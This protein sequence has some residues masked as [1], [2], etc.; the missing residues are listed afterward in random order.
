RRAPGPPGGGAAG[1]FP[2]APRPRAPAGGNE[3]VAAAGRIVLMGAL[4]ALF[5][6]AL[7]VQPVWA[8]SEPYTDLRYYMGAL[9]LLLAMKGLFVEWAWRRRRIA[10]AAAGAVLL[11]SSAGAWPFNITMLFTGERTLGLH[12]FQFVREIHRP[13]RDSI[14]AVSDHLLQHAEQDDLVYVAGF[15]DRETLMFT[16]GHRVLFCCILDE[17]SPLPR[18]TI[19]ALGPHVPAG[20]ITPDWIILFGKPVRE[21][22]Q[23]VT[24]HYSVAVQ[25]NVYYYPT[26]RPEINLHAFTPLP[27][28][29]YGVHVLRRTR[30]GALQEAADAL[31]K[32]ERYEEALDAYRA[33]LAIDAEHAPALAGIGVTLFLLQ[34]YEEALQAL[35]QATAA[36][37]DLPAVGALYR[38][39]GRAAQEL[40]RPSAPEHFERALQVDPRDA[41]AI[42]RLAKVRFEQRRYEEALALYRQ[43]AEIADDAQTLA[44]V[45]ATLYH[46]GRSEDALRSFERALALDPDL[47]AA[48]AGVRALRRRAAPAGAGTEP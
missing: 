8:R 24:A 30:T 18:A 16:T 31:R 32:E 28:G 37:P 29:Q 47:E 44:N 13:Y 27:A 38:L 20:R 35:G 36:Q 9:P 5:A 41:D 11:F 43:L 39:M 25:P 46:L 6:A 23:T 19:D 40:G 7:S 34:R 4:F 15:A 2:G 10:G 1:G 12:L 22:W 48:R 45:G 21:Y 42:D 26:Q 17:D 3:P 14:R 33:V